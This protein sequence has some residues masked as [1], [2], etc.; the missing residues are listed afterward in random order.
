MV[1]Y[2]VT[3][4]VELGLFNANLRAEEDDPKTDY[5]LGVLKQII[6]DKSDFLE[7]MK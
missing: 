5:L 1:R 6:N 3:C 2:L 7:E 4:Q